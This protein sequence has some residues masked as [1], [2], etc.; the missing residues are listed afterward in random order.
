MNRRISDGEVKPSYQN[1]GVGRK[2]I[3]KALS[4]GKKYGATRSFLAADECNEAGIH[5]Y[6]SIGFIAGEDES[7]IDMIK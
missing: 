6:T 4:Y 1:K 5:L 2:L 3:M 7:Q